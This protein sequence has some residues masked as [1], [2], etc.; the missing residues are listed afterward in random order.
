[1]L[2]DSSSQPGFELPTDHRRGLR[3]G[4][5]SR[6]TDTV[7]AFGDIHFQRVLWPKFDPMKDRFDRI[8]A[9]ATRT[10]AIGMRRQFGFPFWL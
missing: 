6:L 2:D 1:M 5:Q 10:K 8:P 4:Q 3:F 9:G 7:E